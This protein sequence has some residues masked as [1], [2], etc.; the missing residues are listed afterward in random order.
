[1]GKLFLDI[2]YFLIRNLVRI[3]FWIYFPRTTVIHRERL[4]FKHPA[5]IISNHPNT[6]IDPLMVGLWVRKQLFFLANASL[7]K[8]RFQNWFFNTFFCI[9][10]ERHQDV[11]GRALQ[12]GDSFA[13]CDVHLG[14]GGCLYIAP[15]GASYMERRLRTVKTGTARIALS[16]ESKKDFELG[17]KIIPVGL[18]YTAPN[19]FRSDVVIHI[20]E[21]IS[22]DSYREI[23]KIDHKSAVY[24]LTNDLDDTLR[25][26][27]IDT[28]DEEEQQLLEKIETVLQISN[29]EPPK[30]AYFR[31]QKI[32]QYLKTPAT[33][34]SLPL[35]ALKSKV[36]VY[37]ESLEKY[38]LDDWTLVKCEGKSSFRLFC[39]SSLLL[40]AFPLFLYGWLNNFLA[41]GIPVLI[42]RKLNLYIGYN[43]T[44]KILAGL[45]TFSLFYFIQTQLVFAWSENGSLA[46]IYLFSLVP[47]GLF[48]WK[49]LGWIK[50]IQNKWRYL[51]FSKRCP[52][53]SEK[54]K[55]QRKEMMSSISK[56]LIDTKT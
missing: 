50:K 47:T 46:W 31:S 20:G 6:L 40:V 44:A 49:Y 55:Q 15:E 13:R 32:L 3:C 29:P 34:N 54:L 22:I 42:T 11:N 39:E 41:A 43:S 7:F 18:T 48:A 14:K 25:T 56:Q 33:I 52:V 30:E 24:Q 26:L 38:N 45:L 28:K 35:K 10:I 37:F 1:M 19:Y 5:I 4:H 27:L 16:A 12:N 9:P 8:T 53:E 17:L 51:R 36:K 2:F 23:N 21:S